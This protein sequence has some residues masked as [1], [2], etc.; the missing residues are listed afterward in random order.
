MTVAE[1]LNQ[2][3]TQ[4]MLHRL[5]DR[6]ESLDKMLE[7][8]SEVPNLVAIAT[9]VFDS[10]ARQA[11]AEGIDLQQRAADLLSIV[12]QVT[13]PRNMQ[14]LKVLAD[15]L[16]QIQQA[17]EM[18]DELPNLVAIATDVIDEWAKN[19]KKD[20]VDLEQS[21]KN[22][23]HAALYLGGQIQRD[24]LDRLGYL[25]RSDV[26]S[27]FS[28]ETVGLAGSALSSCRQGSC[29]HPVP[30]R[31]GLLGLLSASR[32]PS[33]QRALAFAVQFSKCFGTLLEQRHPG[34]S[35]TTTPSNS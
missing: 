5:L 10:F 23:L 30:E 8:A 28:V 13:E 6:A 11:A 18:A 12:K 14:A 20:G 29:E 19:L 31:M 33:T 26:L 16:P 9:D 25:L 4:E 15:H 21:L 3:E 1:R 27:E 24:E 35:P 34:S 22:G 2:P 7:M 32:D 17:A